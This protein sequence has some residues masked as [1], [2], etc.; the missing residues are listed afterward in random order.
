MNQKAQIIKEDV[1]KLTFMKI[2]NFHLLKYIIKRVK[3]RP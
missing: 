2:K 1:N 3:S